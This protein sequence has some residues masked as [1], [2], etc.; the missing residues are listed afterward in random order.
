MDIGLL[1]RD[2]H[3]CG[4]KKSFGAENIAC[5][6][7]EEMTVHGLERKREREREKKTSVIFCLKPPS[8]TYFHPFLQVSAMWKKEK[9]FAACN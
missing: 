5:R 4:R 3:V 1:D 7:K 6:I 9:S 2:G 8:Q